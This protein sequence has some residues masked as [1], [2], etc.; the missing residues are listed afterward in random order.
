[1]VATI[2]ALVSPEP[3]AQ[4]QAKVALNQQPASRHNQTP[5]Y[6]LRALVSCGVCQACC[7]ARTT[8][9]GRRYDVCRMKAVP[10]YAQPG[11]PCRSRHIPAQP[12]EDLVW[13][14]LCA[15]LRH[16]EPMAYALERAPGGHWLPQELQARREALRQG[17]ATLETQID[18]LTQASLAE[19]IPLAAYQRRRRTLEETI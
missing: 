9:G 3:C 8:N 4:V 14:D 13:H 18:R 5:A 2:P 16:P 10:R 11:Q 7:M 19:I 15:L 1:M 6:R 12:R 17:R